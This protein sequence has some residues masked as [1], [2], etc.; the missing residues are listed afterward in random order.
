MDDEDPSD[1]GPRGQ[2]SDD[3][4]SGDVLL[5]E[6]GRDDTD[7]SGLGPAGQ[8][9]GDDSSGS[10]DLGPRGDEDNSS[11]ITASGSGFAG[12]GAGDAVGSGAAVEIT[13]I[14]PHIAIP[15]QRDDDVLV[16][17]STAACSELVRFMNATGE[18]E[19]QI[20]SAL[21]R[22]N[23]T[24]F[25]QTLF[26]IK[27]A[28]EYL[29]G[30]LPRSVCPLAVE[31]RITGIAP[32]ALRQH[33][34]DLATGSLLVDRL[35]AN[36][37]ARHLIQVVS[38]TGKPTLLCG[39]AVLKSDET[40][41]RSRS[42]TQ[43]A[44]KQGSS[45][46]ELPQ[47]EAASASAAPAAAV[48]AVGA[49]D[50]AIVVRRSSRVLE[51]KDDV[52]EAAKL[53]AV[54]PSFC[55]TLQTSSGSLL[56]VRLR[57][58]PLVFNIDANTAETVFECH[59]RSLKPYHE[60]RKLMALCPMR[61]VIENVDRAS[62]NDKE[63]RHR[64]DTQEPNGDIVGRLLCDIHRAHTSQGH[65]FDINKRLI[66]GVLSCG[67]LCLTSGVLKR[68]RR[69]LLQC[70]RAR[71]KVFEGSAGFLPDSAEYRTRMAVFDTFLP[72][73]P[74]QEHAAANLRR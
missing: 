12:Q 26:D 20:A 41:L 50:A 48:G 11:D 64:T 63:F 32:Q 29:C 33:S 13:G 21:V 24:R 67:L 74:G 46:H 14:V 47:Q 34:F 40:T 22:E 44:G 51:K 43:T 61:G 66:S 37:Y 36:A 15:V 59:E 57:C 62:S 18:A 31:A 5:Q 52:T 9:D 16:K 68:W 39:M 6:G 28:K 30:E 1:L 53:M 19:L 56:H 3:E 23:T 42:R 73:G 71:V 10:D 65:V 70:I 35:L 25:K 2:A 69:A 60:V 38:S 72:T 17:P 8:D 4:S 55:F 54:H 49:G 27:V 58:P 7:D 45:M